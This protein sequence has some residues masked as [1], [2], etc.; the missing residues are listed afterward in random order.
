V[1]RGHVEVA[2]GHPAGVG[3][4]G[5]QQQVLDDDRQAERHQQRRRRPAAQGPAEQAQLEHQP[6][7]ERQRDHDQH[8]DPQ[9]HPERRHD[10]GGQVGAAHGQ[11]AV[12]Q[13]D[14]AHDPE[15][16]RQADRGQRVG[17]AQEDPLEDVVHPGHVR[18]F[19]PVPG[20]AAGDP[21]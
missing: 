5:L 20:G 2:R 6:Q 13:V 18:T 21:K 14:H 12:G 11:I 7:Q 16:E 10:R 8:G 15:H 3:R 4:V 1:D 17:A 19:P 9:G